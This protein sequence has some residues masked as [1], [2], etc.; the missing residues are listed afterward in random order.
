MP[1]LNKTLAK[2]ARDSE[3]LGALE[4]G[5]YLGALNKV[6]EKDG[7]E[8]PYW[9]WEFS[10]VGDSEGNEMKGGR[11]WENTSLSDRALFRVKSMF[12]A[13]GVEMDTDTN[14]LIGQYVWL[15]IGTEIQAE[16]VGKGKERNILL[17]ALQVE[18]E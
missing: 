3:G 16:G 11:L 14:E 17:S 8:S 10:I 15:N 4:A 13:F 6:D 1:K 9:E 2:K 12:E 18:D 5:T 7:K